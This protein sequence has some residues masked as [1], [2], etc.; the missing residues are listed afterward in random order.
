MLKGAQNLS[1]Q[2]EGAINDFITY[3]VDANTQ[4]LGEGERAAVIYSYKSAFK[5]LPETEAELADAIKIANGRWPSATSSGA[6]KAAKEQ[7]MKIYNRAPDMTNAKDNAAVTVMA[8]GL[9][10]KTENRNLNSEKT[11]IKTFKYVYGRTPSTTEEWNTMQAITYSGAARGTDTD[12]D[13]LT[14][15]QEKKLGTDPK[16]PD[17]DGDGHLDGIEVLNGYDPLKK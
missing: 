4:K 6:E 3:G 7:F 16:N 8:Y 5:K 11:G 15:E 17:T 12:K 10:Q 13:F 14:D 2:S 9:R 1:D